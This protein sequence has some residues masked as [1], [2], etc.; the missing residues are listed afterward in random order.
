LR[1]ASWKE[2]KHTLKIIFA[3]IN[4]QR[5][6]LS[7]SSTEDHQGCRS[8]FTEGE[9]NRTS[10]RPKSRT[11]SKTTTRRH[12]ST[13]LNPGTITFAIASRGPTWEISL[14]TSNRQKEKITGGLKLTV[15]RR[16]IPPKEATTVAAASENSWDRDY[17][18]GK[19]NTPSRS[20]VN[21]GIL[22]YTSV[23]RDT[24]RR[25]IRIG[26]IV[27]RLVGSVGVIVGVLF[28]LIEISIRIVL[29]FGR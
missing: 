11:T 18:Q 17:F 2:V 9:T 27:I 29:Q 5:T 10:R 22:R 14:K 25:I 1:H 20:W 8:T 12:P 26:V 21:L 19:K 15:T 16:I 3:A 13:I 24:Q 7:R 28:G 23:Q 6:N 4:Y